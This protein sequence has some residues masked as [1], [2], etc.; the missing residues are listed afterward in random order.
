M[1]TTGAPAM[2]SGR[3]DK[4]GDVMRMGLSLVFACGAFLAADA[5]AASPLDDL[6]PPKTGASACFVR[7]YDDAHL[8]AHPKQRVTFIAAWMQYTEMPEVARSE[9]HTSELQSRG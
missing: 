9:E 5:R 7:T 8:R 6:I 2:C 3:R 1:P 4:T